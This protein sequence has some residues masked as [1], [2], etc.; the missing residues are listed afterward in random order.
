MSQK[1]LKL[2]CG[3]I[4]L[5]SVFLAIGN[6]S[7]SNEDD[8][9]KRFA[10]Y[11]AVVSSLQETNNDEKGVDLVRAFFDPKD[12]ADNI[13]KRIYETWKKYK[14]ISY[15]IE[16]ISISNDG[17]TGTFTFNGSIEKADGSKITVSQGFKWKKVNGI[18]Y[19]NAE[20]PS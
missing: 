18:W 6:A 1:G 11:M 10:D 17:N 16:D 3:I 14:L 20:I 9:K 8:L 7:N 5:F 19:R 13:A 2:A 4:L 15:S 12:N